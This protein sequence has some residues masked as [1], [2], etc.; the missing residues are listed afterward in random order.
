MNDDDKPFLEDGTLYCFKLT[1]VNTQFTDVDMRNYKSATN[2]TVRATV[3]Q[4][5]PDEIRQGNCVVS[6]TKPTVVSALGAIPKPNSTEVR[7][8]RD[9]SRLHGHAVNDYITTRLLKFQT[10]DDAICALRPHYY[11]A[12]IDL[13]HAYRSVPIHP[14]N[15]QATGCKWRFTGDDFDTFF[16]DTHLLFGAKCSPEIFHRLMQAVRRMMARRGFRDI[17]VYLDDF[18]VIGA[19]YQECKEKYDVLLALLPDLGFTISWQK[20]VPPTQHLTFLGV[21]LDTLT[22]TTT[23]LPEK[24]KE[25]QTLVAQFRNKHRASKHQLQ[26][27]GLSGSV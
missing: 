26:R 19:T 24:L 16:L 23:L 21:Q 25:F 6:T 11:M 7:L 14:A 12:K 17:V 18:L 2:P 15:F 10:L 13:R 3:E 9:C 20:L 1:N 4:T 8:I 5:I 27:L 22:C